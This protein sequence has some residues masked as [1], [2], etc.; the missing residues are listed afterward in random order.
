MKRE[1]NYLLMVA[2]LFTRAQE[3]AY[4]VCSDGKERLYTGKQTNEAVA[5]YLIESLKEQDRKLD[6]IVMLCSPEVMECPVDAAGNKTTYE[7]FREVIGDFYRK[8]YGDAAED[9]F[10]PISYV[11]V[12]NE[13]PD[14][15]LSSLKSVLEIT[16][17]GEWEQNLYIDFTGGVRSAAM[18]LVFMAR[19]LQSRKVNIRRVLYSNIS[20]G[21][22]V[23]EEM[24]KTYGLFE[25]LAGEIESRYGDT[26]RLRDYALE[27]INPEAK[28]E[29]KEFLNL[30]DKQSQAE[31]VN[32]AGEVIKNAKKN[33]ENAERLA[34]KAGESLGGDILVKLGKEKGKIADEA[35]KSGST[36]LALLKQKLNAKTSNYADL[37]NYFRQ[38]FISHILPE[39][40]IIELPAI[41]TQEEKRKNDFE[42]SLTD[43]LLAAYMYYEVRNNKTGRLNSG[44]F[45]TMKKFLWKLKCQP[46]SAPYSVS[47]WF[48]GESF[49]DP[50][51]I[52][53]RLQ[54]LY[55]KMGWGE[56]SGFLRDGESRRIC[57][58][59]LLPCL[60]KEYENGSD[61]RECIELYDDLQAVYARA[62][63]PLECACNG[64]LYAG[65]R[66]LYEDIRERGTRLLQTVYEGKSTPETEEM[67]AKMGKEPCSYKELI[68]LLDED[69]NEWMVRIIYPFA[70]REDALKPGKVMA[71]SGQNWDSFIYDLAK[72]FRS[73]NFIRNKLIHN[74]KALRSDNKE[75]ENIVREIRKLVEFLEVLRP[76]QD[77]Q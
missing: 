23:I 15:M 43:E 75:V 20:N 18:T 51:K 69:R 54:E 60:Q 7:Y 32:Q 67:F 21:T 66:A 8:N 27:N 5:K 52:M 24:T 3:I 39:M 71:E 37:L 53:N 28:E 38:E 10:V 25:Y 4:S 14:A 58:E 59:N 17:Q 13:K 40:K 56:P 73:I 55:R 29:A 6:K 57:R 22:G 9:L 26:A 49:F 34:K 61:L 72:C 16:E 70:V 64:R 33:R 47:S 2:S 45:K 31:K 48:F 50:I 42:N 35:E 65:Y 11:N 41:G 76:E 46:K 30:L 77:K 74:P 12:E 1:K 62:G 36:T 19:I 63:Y 68:E 44:F